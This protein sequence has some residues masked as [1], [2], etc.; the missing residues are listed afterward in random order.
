MWDSTLSIPVHYLSI[1]FPLIKN[2]GK[3]DTE[4]VVS[5]ESKPM[6]LKSKSLAEGK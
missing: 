1:N 5:L 6:H 2:G 3:N 4:R